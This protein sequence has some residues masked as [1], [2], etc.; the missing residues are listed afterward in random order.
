MNIEMTV[1]KA[2][3]FIIFF[4][5]FIYTIYIMF[6]LFKN[7]DKVKET[8][9]TIINLELAMDPGL[10]HINSKLA[11]FEY[12]VDGER[13]ISKNTINMS[14]NAE[15]GDVKTINY[16]LDNPSIL[17]KVNMTYFYIVSVVSIISLLLGIIL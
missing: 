3:F 16:F 11:T 5:T 14:L 6:N 7:R 9:G 15:V 1:E 4:I 2:F 8:E 12:F 10:P 17:Y 13:Y